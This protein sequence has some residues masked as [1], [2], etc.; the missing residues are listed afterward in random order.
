MTAGQQLI[1]GKTLLSILDDDCTRVVDCRFDLSDKGA[2]QRAYLEAHIPGAVF[3]DLEKD[4]SAEPTMDSGRHPLPDVK[5]LGGFFSQ[6]GIDEHVNV[7]VYDS[8][9]G[10]LAARCWWLLKWLGH[11]KV[12]LLDGGFATWEA[13]GRSVEVGPV[14]VQGRSFIANADTSAVVTLAEI[15]AAYPNIA[16]LRLFDA[17][18]GARFS[19]QVEPFDSVAGHVPGA[20]SFP[21]SRSLDASGVWRSVEEL[22]SLWGDALGA[23][24]RCASSD[25]PWAVMC[26]SGVTA[27]H[28]AL[29]AAQAGFSAPRLYAGSWSEWI[30]DPERPVATGGN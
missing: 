11:D 18:D 16:E 9:N 3:A 2:G 4:L 17:R 23:R 1:D 20:I 21:L 7:V 12:R 25:V 24:S 6:C 13:A 29:S 30:R 22:Q 26:G 5:T 14:S 10:A 27:C 8:G 19:G 28:L 15:L